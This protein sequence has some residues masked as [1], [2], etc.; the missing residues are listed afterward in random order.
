MEEDFARRLCQKTLPE[1]FQE[2]QTTSRK[3]RRPPDDFQEV[4]TTFRKSKRLKW[5]SSGR[6]P[7]S[8]LEDFLEVVW[9]TSWKSSGRLPGSRLVDYILDE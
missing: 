6:L 3:S 4:Q 9:K 7:G 1:D 5:K 8:R 2:V